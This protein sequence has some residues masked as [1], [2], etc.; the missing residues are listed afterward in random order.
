M[1]FLHKFLPELV[2]PL[3]L[4]FVLLLVAVWRRQWRLAQVAVLLLYL[5]SNRVV[6]YTLT[7][8]VEQWAVALEPASMPDADAIAVSAF[9]GS[10]NETASLSYLAKIIDAAHKWGVAVMAEMVP[11]GFGAS[12]LHTIENI[13]LGARVGTDLSSARPGDVD[14]DGVDDSFVWQSGVGEAFGYLFGGDAR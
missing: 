13:A 6:A 8:T 4:V 1:E 3:N 12:E 7:R 14:G 11:G 5:A 2:L 9:P 10:P